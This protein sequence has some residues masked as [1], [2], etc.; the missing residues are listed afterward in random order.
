MSQN[1]FNK[2]PAKETNTRGRILTGIA[3]NNKLKRYKRMIPI[4]FASGLK[5]LDWPEG[6]L[7]ALYRAKEKYDEESAR[8]Q[9][10]V[11]V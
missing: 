2:G 6:N 10:F 9:G 8:I 7:V 3:N 11:S 1:Q 4:S 5:K